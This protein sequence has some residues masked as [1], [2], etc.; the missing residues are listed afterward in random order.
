LQLVGDVTS[1]LPI[2]A[3]LALAASPPLALVVTGERVPLPEAARAA[4]LEAQPFTRT[5]TV[6]L[7]RAA[8]VT[9]VARRFEKASRLC[10][11][12]RRGAASVTLRCT[13]P[14][15]RATLETAHAGPPTLDLR[16]LT[17]PPW[18]PG[19]EGPPLAAF[20]TTALGLGPCPGATPAARGECL[21]AEGDL[22]GAGAAFAEAAKAG[23]SPL[24]ELRLGDLALRADEPE[25]A[26]GHWRRAKEAFPF[27]RL[28][29]AR[30]CELDPS[31]LRS[32]QLDALFEASAAAP[33]VRA[34]LLLRRVRL[35]ALAGDLAG[36]AKALAPEHEAG[37]AC[38]GT[39]RAWCRSVLALALSL[40]APEGTAALATYLETPG[41]AEGADALALARAAAAQAEAA[42]APVFAANLLASFSGR[43]PPSEE[44]SHLLRIARLYLAG[45]DRPRAEEVALFARDRLAPRELARPEW[46]AVR[47]TLRAPPPPAAAP[48]ADPD[49]DLTAA[50]AALDAARL[51]SLQKGGRP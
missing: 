3:A 49:P 5:L 43:I 48:S 20:D 32:D 34:D 45:G 29:G 28:A 25:R 40:P 46:A 41:R 38:A 22:A 37:G 23:L 2:A 13:S 16:L 30:L 9:G 10:P 17:V 1:G 8:D 47:R 44:P 6:H 26:R 12:V 4:R 42:G 39:A 33:S 35:R 51:V 18:R 7:P 15:V 21:L 27:G 19:E 24:A 31:C 14:N 11:Q 36:A 50:R